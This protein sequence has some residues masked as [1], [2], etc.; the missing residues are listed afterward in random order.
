MLG[1]A[2]ADLGEPRKAIGL[3][4]D[5]LVIV[6]RLGDRQGEAHALS[7]V[8]LVHATLGEHSRAIVLYDEALSVFHELGARGMEAYTLWNLALAYESEGSPAEAVPRA[9]AALVICRA[10][11]DPAV[12][13]MERWFRQHG[14]EP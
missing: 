1:N 4:E 7:C 13:K 14:M 2:W 3:Y 11:E 10:V 12:Q 6:R 8:G 5:W 9:R